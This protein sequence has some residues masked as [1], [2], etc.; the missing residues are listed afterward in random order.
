MIDLIY[1]LAYAVITDG[2]DQAMILERPAIMAISV[3]FVA[4]LAQHQQCGQLRRPSARQIHGGDD[5]GAGAAGRPGSGRSGAAGGEPIHGVD[6][7][8]ARGL[9]LRRLRGGRRLR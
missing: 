6:V 8:T 9:R 2:E 1:V 3:A 7:L 5:V 4:S